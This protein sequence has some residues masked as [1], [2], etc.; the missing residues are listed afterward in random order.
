MLFAFSFLNVGIASAAQSPQLPLAGKAIPQF[1]Q[2]LPLLSVQPGGTMATIFGNQALN[3]HMC[4]FDAKVLPPG[5]LVPGVQPLTRV[6][7]YI[8][9]TPGVPWAGCPTTP[10]DTYLGPVIVNTRATAGAP[11]PTSI[12]WINDLGNTA[13]TGVLAYKYSTDQ[14]LHWADPLGM[15]MN[16]CNHMAMYP[17]F[18]SLCSLNYG[19]GIPGG[20]PIP[21][22]VHLHGG[23]VPAELDGGPDAWFTSDGMYKGHGYYT[24]PGAAANA[25]LYKYPNVQEAAPIWFHD[26]TLGATRLNV[27]AG[28]AGAYYIVDPTLNLPTNLQPVSEVVPVVLQ[29]R[30]FDTNGQL[31]F[32]ADSAGGLLWATNPE[33]PYWSPEFVGDTIVVNGKAW[34]YLNVQAKRYRFLFLNGSN[35]RTY[36]MF[37][38][39]QAAATNGPPLYV[40]GT[41][42]GYLDTPVM[43]DPA[44]GQRLVI[45]PGER[46]EVIV[47]FAGFGGTNL[48][49]RNTG[50]TPFPKGAPPQ[51]RTLGRIMQFRVALG[52]VTDHSYDPVSGVALRSGAQ[53][54]QRL[55][56]PAT[57]T[58]A[59][60]VVANKTRQLTLNEVMGMPMNAVDPVTGLLTAYPGG[61]LEI[62]V[63][64]TKWSGKRITGVDPISGM[65]TMQPIPGFKL[66]GFGYNYLSELPQEGETEVWEVVN[67]TADAHPI[68]LHLVQFQL[69]NRQ[70]FNVTT[71]NG[72]YG[73]SFPVGGWDF[74]MGMACMAGVFCPAYGPPLA[75]DPALNPL[76]GG[77]LGGN[78]DVT[79]YLQG[80]IMPP[81]PNEAG[82]KDTVIMLPGQVTRIVARYAPTDLAT[83]TA[84]SML[85]YPFDPSGGGQYTYVWHCHIID[86]EDNEMM[87]QA[88]VTPM[89]GVIRTVMKGIDY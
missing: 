14:T 57:G 45:Q 3:I 82:W 8:P 44:L 71:Y 40:I 76:S 17:A 23:E 26:H 62:L 24:F 55:V 12:T 50:R 51:G 68:H 86:H 78:P 48:I 69:I 4:E 30:M 28:L 22:V 66:D 31:F 47:D 39:N 70:N 19:E 32:Q 46:Y 85:Y 83:T 87:R 79:P 49:I 81:L 63:N 36:E 27:Y 77:K 38:W 53:V 34:P 89:L 5:T 13:A 42:G 52:V 84:P 16:M 67:L 25:S 35:A 1:M 59:A 72:V 58:L 73:A 43:L 65:Y 56:N 41:D 7:G 80:A 9:E 37:L 64:N 20:A 10:Q 88:A 2:P 6:W 75:Y 54:I 11:N 60:G 18:R 74:T 21:A 61:P 33:H 29:D 15:E